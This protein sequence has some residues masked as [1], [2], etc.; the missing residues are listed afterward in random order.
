MSLFGF[1]LH[2]KHVGTMS[3][4]STIDLDSG[5]Q[6]GKVSSIHGLGG[7][8]IP[9]YPSRP[10]GN[11]PRK[12]PRY[13]LIPCLAMGQE[14]RTTLCALPTPW[15]ETEWLGTPKSGK[16]PARNP[17][18]PRHRLIARGELARTLA[19]EHCSRLLPHLA[20]SSSASARR[21]TPSPPEPTDR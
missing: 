21:R 15:R 1:S 13:Q 11:R 12:I 6:L 16:N 9:T 17:R 3:T 5:I 19:V 14:G 8:N 4:K 7:S 10:A 2:R 18:V 20:P